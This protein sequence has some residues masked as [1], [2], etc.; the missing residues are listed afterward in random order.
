MLA[1]T[2]LST[3]AVAFG[4]PTC[5]IRRS[6][7]PLMSAA[8]PP[9]APVPPTAPA[10]DDWGGLPGAVKASK[11]GAI[12]N[13]M[14]QAA[15]TDTILRLVVDNYDTLNGVNVATAMH[16]LARLTKFK[17]A[18]RDAVLRDPRYLKLLDGAVERVPE[19]HARAIA[20]ILW[21][22][23]TMTEFPPLLLKP[24]LTQ[25]AKY[26]EVGGFEPQH[27]SIMVWS[28]ATLGVK[29]VKL[30]EGI[31]AR[32]LENVKG[33]NTQNCAN[34]LQGAAKLK[35]PASDL[36][37]AISSML[38]QNGLVEQCKP[39]EVA[40]L[41]FA[42]AMLDDGASSTRAQGEAPPLLTALAGR[43]RHSSNLAA[44]SSRQLVTVMWAYA[45]LDLQPDGAALGEWVAHVQQGHARTPL[46]A[47][48]L[49]NC[50]VALTKLGQDTAWLH[51]EQEG[52]EE[53]AAVPEIDTIREK[54]AA[55]A[56]AAAARPRGPA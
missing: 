47:A 49:R 22:C 55:K 25:V 32:A 6:A 4:P 12:N 37:P 42:V 48:D 14:V 5:S 10:V 16:H 31:E 30:L 35:Y 11:A 36:L 3:V 28:F 2:L 56:Q 29:P 23:G 34:I 38:L 52:E 33:F 27:L 21:S 54:L 8:A 43:A 7:V 15:D 46:L 41:A 51:P 1:G 19:C 26:L 20:D 17:R 13:Q 9:T 45:K 53:E 44:F 39:V 40:D 24:V 50:D 18:E